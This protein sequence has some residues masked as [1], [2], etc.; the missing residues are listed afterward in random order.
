MCVS[1][2]AISAAENVAFVR[3]IPGAFLGVGEDFV[4]NLDLSEEGGG[5][6]DVAEVAVGMEFEGFFAIGAF[7]SGL[8]R[9]SERVSSM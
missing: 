3:I 9:K 4:G 6:F 1:P 5:A 2:F 7:E 8:V